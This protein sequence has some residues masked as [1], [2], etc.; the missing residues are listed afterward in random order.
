M[1]KCELLK[2]IQSY[3]FAAYDLLLYLDT[4]P[5]DKKAFS[6]FRELV[7]KAKQLVNEYQ[8]EY[9]PLSAFASAESS[10]FDWLECPWPWEKEANR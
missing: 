3:R 1:S 8:R 4:H 2:K 9:G 7:G 5:D 10:S 6:L